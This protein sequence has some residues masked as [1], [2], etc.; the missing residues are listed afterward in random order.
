MPDPNQLPDAHAGARHFCSLVREQL[1][2]EK[3]QNVF[4]AG[5]RPGEEALFIGKNPDVHWASVFGAGSTDLTPYGRASI[6]DFP[7]ADEF[8]A[9]S[10][11]TTACA[12]M[13]DPARSLDDLWQLLFP[14]CLNYVGTPN[15]YRAVG[16]PP[17]R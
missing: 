13:S 15:R 12:H 3:P 17:R 7:F 14:G 8:S 16:T 2:P 6:V 4:V 11:I 9:S 10:G 5:C 1:A